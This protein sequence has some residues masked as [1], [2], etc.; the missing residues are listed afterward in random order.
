METTDS[1]QT[2]VPAT[3]PSPDTNKPKPAGNRRPTRRPPNSRPGGPRRRP[4]GNSQPHNSGDGGEKSDNR[5]KQIIPPID[6]G[7]IR[8]IPLGGVEEIGKNMTAIEFDNTILVIDI[9][10]A[11]PGE[12]TPGIDYIIPDSTYVE[13]NKHKIKAVIITHGHLDHIGGIPYVMPKLGNPPLYTSLLTSV[14]IKKRQEEFPYLPKLDIRLVEKHESLQL[15]DLKIRFFGA[16][17]TIPDCFGVIV[18]TPYGN[19]IFTG[20]LKIENKDGVPA[21]F[22]IDTYT[23]LGAE[24]NLL[25]IADSTNV[26]KEGFSYPEKEVHANLK[27]IIRNVPGRI[28]IGTFASLFDRIISV[29]QSAEEL[30]K[31]VAVEGRSMKNN[32]E[33]AKELG[34]LKVNKDT[35]IPSES[36]GDYPDDRLV[37]LATGA[38]GDEFA[39]LMRIS[40]KE[41]R[42]FKLKKGD[43]VLLSS[44]VIPGNEKSVDRLKDNLA[45]LGA[46]IIHYG[47]ANV[48]SSGHSYSGEMAWIHKMIKPKFFMPV[49]GSH[50]MLRVHEDLAIS[51]GMPEKN[52]VVPDNGMIV[53]II[54]G[55]TKMIPRKETASSRLVMVDGLGNDNVQEVVIRDRQVL[56]QDGMFV[57]IAIID[58]KTGKVR[59]SPD[60]ISRGFVYLKESQDLLHQV[61]GLTKKTIE[62]ATSKM[63]PI[64]FDYLKNSVREDLG[65]YL[66]QKT[67]KRPIILPVLIEV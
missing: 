20:D 16:T 55:G 40:N 39:A 67:H 37:V 21:Q 53:E 14:M 17:H 42:T 57:V 41:H 29:V 56:S 38:Q 9:G 36:I 18:E 66:F 33:I 12:E 58:V 4:F 59:K 60:I 65:R 34:I 50:Y 13:D 10:L 46:K 23:K 25:L 7:V 15:G 54:E 5:Q 6:P 43:T 31:K 11:F 26:T 63:H 62:D 3:V 49:H 22:E 8:V 35:I 30:G 48:H 1:N 61:R 47:I 45:R 2:A 64:N 28:V 24:N 52:I 51:L 27:E 19:V 32:I 44:S